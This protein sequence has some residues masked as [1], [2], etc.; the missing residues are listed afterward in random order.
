MIP[1]SS[2]I[3]PSYNTPEQSPNLRRR[4]AIAYNN[5]LHCTTKQNGL[6]PHP[7]AV[8]PT[9]TITEKYIAI[10]KLLLQV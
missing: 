2:T 9:F 10:N 6:L 8:E 3:H 4:N 1:R 5:D 7:L